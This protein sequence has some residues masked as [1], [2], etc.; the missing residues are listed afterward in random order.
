MFPERA[1]TAASASESSSKLD[2]LAGS[3]P[4]VGLYIELERK[5]QSLSS[6]DR[7]EKSPAAKAEVKKLTE[8]KKKLIAEERASG[9]TSS[10]KAMKES[11][12][13]IKQER[14]YNRAFLTAMMPKETQAPAAPAPVKNETPIKN[15]TPAPDAVKN[16]TPAQAPVKNE[17]PTKTETPAQ[18]QAPDATTVPAISSSVDSKPAETLALMREANALPE[19]KSALDQQREAYAASNKQEADIKKAASQAQ[20]ITKTQEKQLSKL[21]RSSDFRLREYSSAQKTIADKE[22]TAEER[23]AAME[24]QARLKEEIDKD[25]SLTGVNAKKQIAS[26]D[27]AGETDRKQEQAAK[28]L[29]STAASSSRVAEAKGKQELG[30][31]AADAGMANAEKRIVNMDRA[32]YKAVQQFAQGDLSQADKDK[33]R[34]DLTEKANDDTSSAT[35][36]SKESAKTSL[37]LMD[38]MEKAASESSKGG[39][40]KSSSKDKQDEPQVSARS[41]GA[42]SL[43]SAES[44]S[45]ESGGSESTRGIERLC[46]QILQKLTELI[47]G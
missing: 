45:S 12:G 38:R 15:E 13:L 21:E 18:A 31:V 30:K 42:S 17:T 5:V 32:D 8:E 19:Q 9:R 44:G 41:S 27:K 14:A 36:K 1:Q 23:A 2:K 3:S 35:V 16:E 39:E 37:E 43:Y 34:K 10:I 6:S 7:Y 29:Q 46:I 25:D 33:M 28:S 20:P 4:S 47:N 22:S 24:T 26:F 40:Q 11:Q